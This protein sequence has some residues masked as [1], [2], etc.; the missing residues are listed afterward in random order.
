MPAF[1]DVPIGGGFATLGKLFVKVDERHAADVETNETRLFW[2][3]AE[4]LPVDDE[5]TPLPEPVK[6]PKGKGRK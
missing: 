1:S 6:T 5:P 4:V 2:D 3:V